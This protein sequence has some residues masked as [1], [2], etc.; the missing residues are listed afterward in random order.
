MPS[1]PVLWDSTRSMKESQPSYGIGY[2]PAWAQVIQG[3]DLRR[4]QCAAVTGLWDST[5]GI[6]E[7]QP[8]YGVDCQ[9]SILRS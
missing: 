6:C 8:S 3:G 7:R 4:K 2:F 9:G 5:Q 1:H